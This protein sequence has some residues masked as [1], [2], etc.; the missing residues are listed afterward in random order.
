MNV[1]YAVLSLAAD[2]KKINPRTQKKKIYQRKK[3]GLVPEGRGNWETEPP[4]PPNFYLILS[5][6]PSYNHNTNYLIN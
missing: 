6:Q 1:L 2:K 5:S 3:A 4:K